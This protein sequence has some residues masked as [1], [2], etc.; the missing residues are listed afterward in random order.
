MKR[1]ITIAV[2]L[3]LILIKYP[4][5]ILC[6][7]SDDI[8]NYQYALSLAQRGNYMSASEEI[9]RTI[10]QFPDLQN[11]TDLVGTMFKWAEK[12]EDYH[13]AILIPENWKKL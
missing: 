8:K 10:I 5:K 12:S 1:K 13:Y 9:L 11:D 3:T 7:I 4:L 6:A 2:V